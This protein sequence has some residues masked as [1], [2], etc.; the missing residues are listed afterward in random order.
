[1]EHIDEATTGKIYREIP[2]LLP[3]LNVY[4]ERR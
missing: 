4:E 2:G 1:V 3:R